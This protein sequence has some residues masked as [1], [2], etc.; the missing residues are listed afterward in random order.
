[1]RTLFSRYFAP[2]PSKLALLSKF[3]LI[4]S[5]ILLILL[6]AFLIPTYG[7]QTLALFFLPAIFVLILIRPVFGLY[8]VA[9]LLP[10]E[11][12]IVIGSEI[13]GVR[14]AALVVSGVWL[15]SKI[16]RRESFAPTFSSTLFKTILAFLGVIILS[17]LVATDITYTYSG[18]T[19]LIRMILFGILALDLIK[20]WDSLDS[21]IKSLLLGALVAA[22]LTLQQ[23]FTGGVRRA[24]DDISGG[25][26]ATA[27]VLTLMLPYAF[28]LFRSQ[29]NLLWRFLGLAYSGLAIVAV[30]V[31]FSRT[32]YIFMVLT[33]L[34][35]NL[36]TIRTGKGRGAIILLLLVFALIIGLSYIPLELV[37]QRAETILPYLA[38]TF[39]AGDTEL[40]QR[41]FLWRV[42][43]Y[44]FRDHPFLGVGYD[45][46][47][48]NFRIYRNIVPG[49][50]PG[51]GSR[52]TPHSSY[53][54]LLAETGLIGIALW[55]SVLFVAFRNLY[56]SRHLL[57]K[58]KNSQHY[59]LLWSI[60]IS[61]SLELAYGITNNIQ[62]DKY[63]WLLIGL[64]VAVWRLVSS[65]HDSFK[66]VEIDK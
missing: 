31:T 50:P 17:G 39:T 65:T 7:L 20:S 29:K 35:Q 33:I 51:L 27:A 41:G 53:L 62:K 52:H 49:R 3:A 58:Y 18:V 37:A 10:I 13:T 40:S 42:A 6:I 54:G 36:E 28:Y 44:I 5:G 4:E 32:S 8:I 57:G 61:F 16:I 19:Q 12:V 60:M 9:S 26:N 56:Q 55:L 30:A 64:S 21:L 34:V 43:L 24:G 14:I 15:A 47:P 48:I 2:D 25:Q 1:M 23:Y 38:S 22:A 66:Q 59:Q 46:Y 45:N 63:F 11:N